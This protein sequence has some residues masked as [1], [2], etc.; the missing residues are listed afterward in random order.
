MHR[1][2]RT[3]RADLTPLSGC[4][5]AANYPY[6]LLQQTKL[7]KSLKEST[8]EKKAVEF[9]HACGW[10]FFKLAK[11]GK[12]GTPDRLF[13]R[14]GEAVFIEFKAPGEKPTKLQL[15]RIR[16]L[17]KDGFTATWFDNLDEFKNFMKGL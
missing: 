2:A 3:P 4:P 12:R 15:Y 6:N 8:L 9:A 1:H 13:L 17:I 5:S 11:T 10:S 7:E 16:E 14:N